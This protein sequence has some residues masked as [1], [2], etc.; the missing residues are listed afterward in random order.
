[1]RI[2]TRTPDRLPAAAYRS[3]AP[4]LVRCGTRAGR[5]PVSGRKARD[6]WKGCHSRTRVTCSD[7]L[8]RILMNDPG[9]LHSRIL[10]T[11]SRVESAVPRLRG[12]FGRT[13]RLAPTLWG[14]LRSRGC[15][16]ADPSWARPWR[17]CLFRIPAR[18]GSETS[19]GGP[20]LG[21]AGGRGSN[22]SGEGSAQL[23]PESEPA[24]AFFGL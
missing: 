11:Q 5:D 18:S 19:P 4:D 8:V 23:A 3:L 7:A 2:R 14:W 12:V 6:R 1:M 21:F 22:R 9:R 17:I 10:A 15:S 13:S 20:G 24:H 16:R